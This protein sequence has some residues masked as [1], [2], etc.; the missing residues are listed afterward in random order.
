MRNGKSK[1]IKVG[2]SLYL[3]LEVSKSCTSRKGGKGFVM[4]VG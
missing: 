2:F 4:A 1:W 3:F